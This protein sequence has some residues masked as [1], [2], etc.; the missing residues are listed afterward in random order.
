MSQEINSE[1]DK[2]KES[3]TY[4]ANKY[5]PILSDSIIDDKFTK[6][7]NILIYNTSIT[8]ESYY[9]YVYYVVWNIL[10]G[11]QRRISILTDLGNESPLKSVIKTIMQQL[12]Y[13]D[14]AFNNM[15]VL[16]RALRFH[17]GNLVFYKNVEVKYIVGHNVEFALIEQ[18]NPNIDRHVEVIQF[19]SPVTQH[20]ENN[21]LIA[22]LGDKSNEESRNKIKECFDYIK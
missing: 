19:L 14:L 4:F 15:S 7:S 12:K 18:F 10:F 9:I 1:Y 5:A 3:F 2:C 21:I 8:Y 17:C 11:E 6:H 16:Q 20:H 22:M 13:N